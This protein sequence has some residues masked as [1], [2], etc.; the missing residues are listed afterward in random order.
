MKA[1]ICTKY[2]SPEVLEVQEVEKPIPKDEELLIRVI[3]TAV[4]SGDVRVRGLVVEGF[5]KLVMQ[6]ILGFSKPKKPILGTVFSG[7]VESIGKNVVSFKSGDRVFGMTGFQFGAYAEYLTIGEKSVV[8]SM[9]QNASFEEAVSLIFGGQTALYFLEKAKI[10]ERKNPKVLIIGST[11]AVGTS[12]VQIAKS[13]GGLVSAVCSSRGENLMKELGISNLFLY[14]K[15]DFMQT[16][17][18]YDIIFDAVGKYDKK[19]IKTLLNTRGI[20]KSVE[21]LDVASETKEQL[22]F[23]KKKYEAGKLKAVIDKTYSF[24]EVVEAHRYVD[25]GRKKGNVVIKVGKE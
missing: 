24:E 12:A 17:E 3:S 2:G 9:P 20:F 19:K 10:Q 13:Y 14:D 18:K 23:L 25:S 8:T 21:G 6:V 11:G 1:I 5:M 16:N 7:T 4:N 15:E 22:L